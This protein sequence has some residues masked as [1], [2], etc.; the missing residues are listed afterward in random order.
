LQQSTIRRLPAVL[1]TFEI[2]RTGSRSFRRSD[3]LARNSQ[4]SG[5][6]ELLVRRRGTLLTFRTRFAIQ[7]SETDA[8]RTGPESRRTAYFPGQGRQSLFMPRE[9]SMLFSWIFSS[10]FRRAIEPE[11]LRHAWLPFPARHPH[12][13]PPEAA[14][15]DLPKACSMPAAPPCARPL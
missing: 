4:L 10:R 2:L 3:L 9:L 5:Y 14:R 7:L 1:T 8:I 6:S 13:S 15:G 12:P 11:A